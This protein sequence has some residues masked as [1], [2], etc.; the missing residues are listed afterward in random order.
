VQRAKPPFRADHVGSLLRPPR[1]LAARQRAARGEISPAVLTEIEDE[2][3]REVIRRQEEAGLRSATDGEYRRTQWH[4]DFLTGLD[5]VEF[6]RVRRAYV[7]QAVGERV[8]PTGE[9]PRVVGKVGFSGH[10]MI[11]HFRFL[12]DHTRVTPKMTIPAPSVLHFRNGMAAISGD[13]Y[14]DIGEFFADLAQAYR[15]AV[16]AFAD[17]GCRYLQF[18]ETSLAYLCDPAQRQM[19][20]DRGD[21][22]VWLLD[23]YIQMVNT[24]VAGI[25]DDMTVTMHMCRGNNRSNWHAQGGYEPIAE[26]VFNQVNVDGFFLEYDSDRAG[27]FGPLRHLPPGKIAVLGLVTSKSGALESPDLVK[28]RIEQASR[29]ADPGQL[30]LSPQCGF[31]S[32]EVGN[33]LTEQEQWRKIEFIVELASDV[34]G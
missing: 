30:C 18:D 7:P 14:P 28:A 4:F 20:A 24:A 6:P 13:A 29:Y 27:G 12:H 34:W 17:A 22:P 2:E 10:P 33:I 11:G 1:L 8:Q 25:P 19:L 16:Q 3:I 31:A 21:D 5:G 15:A 23:R 26:T 32:I 9:R